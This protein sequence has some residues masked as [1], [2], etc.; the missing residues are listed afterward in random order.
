MTQL[1]I[2]HAHGT[3]AL[4][5]N[6]EDDN[7]WWRDPDQPWWGQPLVFPLFAPFFFFMVIAIKLLMLPLM[8]F[9]AFRRGK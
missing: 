3:S 7:R 8:I 1:V 9:I 2:A 5:D 6:G 4:A